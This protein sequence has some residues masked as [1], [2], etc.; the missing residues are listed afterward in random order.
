MHAR[1]GLKTEYLG[2]KWFE[3]VEACSKKAEELGMLSYAYDENGWPSGFCGGKLLEE[4]ENHD[5]YLTYSI[6]EYDPKATV[7]YS[8]DGEKLIRAHSGKNN[9]NVYDHMSASTADILDRKV[10]RKFLDSTH[11]EYKKRDTYHLKGFFTDEPQYYRW[12]T[13]FTHALPDYYK[14][15]YGKDLYGVTSR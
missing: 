8:L 9:L 10:V 14:K 3:C 6:G 13:A 4:E 11:E 1:G 5:R 7:S 15:Q 2:E 12:G